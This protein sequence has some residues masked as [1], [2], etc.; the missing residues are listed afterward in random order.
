MK[1][2]MRANVEFPYKKTRWNC[3]SCCLVAIQPLWHAICA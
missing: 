3:K 1:H 2:D